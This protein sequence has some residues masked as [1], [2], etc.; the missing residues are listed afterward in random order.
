M[1]PVA[2]DKGRV[3]RRSSK[4]R[5]VDAACCSVESA[6]VFER[7]LEM[8][9]ITKDSDETSSEIVMVR[10]SWVMGL[11]QRCF[12][13]SVF[14]NAAGGKV[15][16]VS[17]LRLYD[18]IANGTVGKTAASDMLKMVG[19]SAASSQ[20]DICIVLKAF[21][22]G[23]RVVHL[24]NIQLTPELQA[25]IKVTSSKSTPEEQTEVFSESALMLTA[26]C[27][28]AVPGA[29]ATCACC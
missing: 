6:L 26:G 22:T 2:E 12:H 7:C 25:W 1:I 11:L 21:N 15:T 14:V 10:L 27:G 4:R 8:I 19:A 24:R 23:N 13:P 18:G 17:L 16:L 20:T 29:Q 3:G 28:A 5:K 9:G